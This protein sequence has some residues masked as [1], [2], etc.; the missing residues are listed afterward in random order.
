MNYEPLIWNIPSKIQ[1]QAFLY[2]E[3]TENHYSLPFFNIS[4]HKLDQ[5]FRICSCKV[6]EIDSCCQLICRNF[7]RFGLTMICLSSLTFMF[8]GIPFVE[9][10]E[11]K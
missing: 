11:I 9:V 10:T 4:I 1:H 5:L 8:A 6:H 2:N 7:N 3:K